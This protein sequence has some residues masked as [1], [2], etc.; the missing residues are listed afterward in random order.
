MNSKI[1]KFCEKEKEAFYNAL[2]QNKT[3]NGKVL[4]EYDNAK[5][6]VDLILNRSCIFIKEQIKD[7]L[8]E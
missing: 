2:E 4:M 3:N 6:I 1:N 8:K 5:R 7:G